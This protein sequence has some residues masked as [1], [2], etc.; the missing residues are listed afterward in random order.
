[1]RKLILKW[2]VAAIAIYAAGY[3][4]SGFE[5][6]SAGAAFMA[7]FLF[8]LLN[9]LLKPI[10]TILT[11][12]VTIL[13]LGLFLF[14]LNGL[15]LMLVDALMAGIQVDGI[16]SAILATVVISVITMVLNGVFGVNDKKK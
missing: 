12:P 7:A 1:M 3:L 5:V 15:M 4:L 11:L 14:V 2:I 6:S 16:F 8:G 9:T 13:T 10:L